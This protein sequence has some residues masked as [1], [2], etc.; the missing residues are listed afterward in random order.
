MGLIRRKRPRGPAP[1]L[2]RTLVD[3]LR[4]ART[5]V[6]N[7]EPGAVDRLFELLERTGAESRAGGIPQ[8]S[9]LDS[10]QVVH[11]LSQATAYE[12]PLE[13]LQAGGDDDAA[14]AVA[15]LAQRAWLL[16]RTDHGPIDASQEKLAQRA[17]QIWASVLAWRFPETWERVR[18]AWED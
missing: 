11:R 1:V 14:H 15:H 12:I 4:D 2:E 8:P 6:A 13:L 10:E 18:R 3:D 16:R 5:A 17:D 7:G 9:L